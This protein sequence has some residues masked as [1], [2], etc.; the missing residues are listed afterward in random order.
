MPCLRLLGQN[1]DVR[2]VVS[3]KDEADAL[4]VLLE[5]VDIVQKGIAVVNSGSH[6]RVPLQTMALDEEKY[7]LFVP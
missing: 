3:E 2:L 6:Y 1:S 7:R 4:N 5:A